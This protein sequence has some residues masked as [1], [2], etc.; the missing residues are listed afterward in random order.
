MG[1]FLKNVLEFLKKMNNWKFKL[2]KDFDFVLDYEIP[3][4]SVHLVSGPN[5]KSFGYAHVRGEY[6][7]IRIFEGYAWDGA[8]PKFSVLDLFWIGTPDGLLYCGKPKIYYSTLI[9][10]FL[11][12]F[13]KELGL[14]RKQCD[15]RFLKEMTKNKFKLRWIYYLVVRMYAILTGK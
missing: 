9:H 4:H 3:E 12:Q 13:R 14:T 8:T 7:Y 15:D 11:L 5:N 6:T 10:D 1:K 2:E